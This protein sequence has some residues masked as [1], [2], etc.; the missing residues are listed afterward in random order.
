MKTWRINSWLDWT[1]VI[2]KQVMRLFGFMDA[3]IFNITLVS[4]FIITDK[5]EY[6]LDSYCT[7][8]QK[9]IDATGSCC[10]NRTFIVLWE[11]HV[12]AVVGPKNLKY[13]RS[14]HVLRTRITMWRRKNVGFW[15]RK[16]HVLNSNTFCK[17]ILTFM[18]CISICTKE[19]DNKCYHSPY[20]IC[21]LQINVLLDTMQKVTEMKLYKNKCKI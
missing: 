3:T 14:L 13:E 16:R 21:F 10:L 5:R 2:S 8:I 20:T 15:H 1:L 7:F 19:L 6:G 17:V 18:C 12:N 9:H 11:S 4:V